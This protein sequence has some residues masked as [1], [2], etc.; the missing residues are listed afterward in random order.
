MEA[1]LAKAP[2]PT[3]SIAHSEDRTLSDVGSIST[4]Q[5]KG[6]RQKKKYRELDLSKRENNISLAYLRKHKAN[7]IKLKDY[8]LKTLIDDQDCAVEAVKLEW[9]LKNDLNERKKQR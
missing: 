4:H 6:K 8:T 7:M 3:I 1:A 2:T 5:K 9:L